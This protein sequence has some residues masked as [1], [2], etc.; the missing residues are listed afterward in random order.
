MA[1]LVFALRVLLGGLLIVAGALKVTH[2]ESLAAAIA[3][4]RLLP[5]AVVVPLAIALPPFE[6][7]FGF[8]LVVGLFTRIASVTV[9]A[10]FALYAAAIASAVIRHIPANCGCFGPGDAATADWPHAGVDLALAALAALVARYSPGSL[11]LDTILSR[12]VKKER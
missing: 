2:T 5:P 6:L 11:A 9:C 8:Y 3:G 7:I 4:Y 12:A 10:A 1:W